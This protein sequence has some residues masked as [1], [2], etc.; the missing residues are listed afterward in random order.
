MKMEAVKK[1]LEEWGE[2]MISTSNGERYE[3]H[4]GDTAFDFENRVIRLK[5]PTALYEIDGDS[6]EVIEKHYGHK[7]E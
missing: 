7:E 4:L 3:I 1:A 5:T 2:L 6:V